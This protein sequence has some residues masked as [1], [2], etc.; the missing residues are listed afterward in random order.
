MTT[1]IWFALKVVFFSIFTLLELW[2]ASV[3][4]WHSYYNEK[5]PESARD[6]LF[7][8]G[9]TTAAM[10]ILIVCYAFRKQPGQLKR[11]QGN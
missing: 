3:L 5:L 1:K 4:I 10:T 8:L 11:S 6:P 2:T 7:S 9:W